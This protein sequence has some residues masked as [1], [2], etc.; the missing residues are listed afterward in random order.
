MAALSL[1]RLFCVSPTEIV[2]RVRI[3]RARRDLLE[4]NAGIKRIGGS[5]RIRN[6]RRT[7]RAFATRFQSLRER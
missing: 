5:V 1:S 7:N 6:V 3:D 4:T 2:E